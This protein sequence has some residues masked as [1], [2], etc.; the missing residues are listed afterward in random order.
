MYVKFFL[1]E[2]ML[3][4]KNAGDCA[5]DSRLTPR[6]AEKI[7]PDLSSAHSVHAY[8]PRTGQQ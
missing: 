6:G 2:W 5:G 8:F 1:A 7:H 3:I 4:Q